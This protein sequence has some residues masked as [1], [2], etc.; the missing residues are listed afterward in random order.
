MK[1]IWAE[2]DKDVTISCDLNGYP[3]PVWSWVK[4]KNVVAVGPRSMTLLRVKQNESG[5]YECWA[6]NT[7]GYNAM[8]VVLTVS[9][10]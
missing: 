5:T 9:S 2:E 4:D 10:K 8:K 3:T 7:H 1:Y 6:N